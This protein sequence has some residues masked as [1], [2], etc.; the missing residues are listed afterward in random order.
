VPGSDNLAARLTLIGVNLVRAR[1]ILWIAAQWLKDKTD[2]NGK[3]E[4]VP[5]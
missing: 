5:Y 4:M 1:N 2:S 3:A